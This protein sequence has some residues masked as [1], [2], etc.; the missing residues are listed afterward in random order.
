MKKRAFLVVFA[1]LIILGCSK[2]GTDSS[3]QQGSTLQ[4]DAS[5][6]FK[7]NQE[8][9][10]ELIPVEGM[11]GQYD[12]GV[13]YPVQNFDPSE[14]T[15]QLSNNFAGIIDNFLSTPRDVRNIKIIL[16]DG[17]NDGKQIGVFE[18]SKDEFMLMKTK[19]ASIYQG[20]GKY[21]KLEEQFQVE[22]NL[23]KYAQNAKDVKILRTTDNSSNET[24]ISVRFKLEK[25][26][27]S[28]GWQKTPMDDQKL[29]EELIANIVRT[30]FESDSAIKKVSIEADVTQKDDRWNQSTMI[31]NYQI[32]RDEFDI[33]LDKWDDLRYRIYDKINYTPIFLMDYVSDS[34][35]L[36]MEFNKTTVANLYDED[37]FESIDKTVA[38]V[39]K[40]AV[41]IIENLFDKYSLVN[42]I[43]LHFKAKIPAEEGKVSPDGIHQIVPDFLVVKASR[44]AYGPLD[45]EKLTP[46][47]ILYNFDTTWSQKAPELKIRSD[48]FRKDDYFRK[49]EF[50]PAMDEAD[51]SIDSCLFLKDELIGPQVKA[52]IKQIK[53]G[54]D[55]DLEE[56]IHDIIAEYSKKL[57][58][59]IHPPFLQSVTFNIERVYLDTTGNE[60][61]VK[62]LGS[63]TLLKQEEANYWFQTES[64][65]EL[66]WI[67]EDNDDLDIDNDEVL[68]QT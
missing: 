22:V 23:L 1:I 20:I 12:I 18:I 54:Y 46:E 28:S 27:D 47:Q 29:F 9:D 48:L 45:I 15:K 52:V 42:N 63:M 49:I 51:I 38:K 11:P 44:A 65:D 8:T 7:F 5:R 64:P 21:M 14:G 19:S 67:I 37:D 32:D 33:I 43:E 62:E 55:A 66:E 35:V 17:S 56:E 36:G 39:E 2:S 24:M 3:S 31:A 4:E 26:T 60:I 13:A 41:T 50:N 57:I 59:N 68:C 16:L 40:D 6:F 30:T 58:F 61:D 10:V 53:E 34:T 25:N